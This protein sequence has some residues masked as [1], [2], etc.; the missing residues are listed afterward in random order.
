MQL[1]QIEVHL[2][3]IESF[4]PA[5]AAELEAFRLRFLS[6]KGIIPELFTQLKNVPADQKRQWGERLNTLKVSA[7]N[8]FNQSKNKFSAGSKQETTED[9][10]LPP[11]P[12]PLGSRH[13]LSIVQQQI[14]GIFQRIGYTISEGPEIEDDWHNFTT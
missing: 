10:T 12:L 6:K 9:L 5:S 7:E 4:S 2:N 1:Q 14:T 13:P 8:K 11:R 3:E